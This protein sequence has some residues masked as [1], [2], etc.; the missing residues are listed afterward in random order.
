M[1]PSKT[2]IGSQWLEG[3]HWNKALLIS[4]AC[5][6]S[7]CSG[8][9]P[10]KLYLLD[11]PTVNT[12]IVDSATASGITSLG[13]SPVV[14]PG[15]ANDVQIASMNANG[16]ITQDD[17]HRWAEEPDDAIT[18]VLSGRLR[19]HAGAT[20][21]IEPWPR[22]YDPVARVEV[23]FDKLV[24]VPNGGSHMVGQ[25]LLLSGDGRALLKAVP[26]DI[27][28]AG[29]DLSNQAFFRA[30]AAGV[31][32]IARLAVDEILVLSAKS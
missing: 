32:D 28:V 29:A 6:L 18:R 1:Q 13:M 2:S 21:L 14:L 30:V 15:Y 11:S 5:V 19:Q 20:V 26:F 27:N 16:T 10:P 8:G 4:C 25:I 12:A 31:D 7:A 24:R 23:S 3:S 9:P 22:D 17:R